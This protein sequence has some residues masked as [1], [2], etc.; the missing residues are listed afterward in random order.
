MVFCMYFIG[1]IIF[2]FFVCGKRG[3]FWC[4][5]VYSNIKL[6]LWFFICEFFERL[7]V[8]GIIVNVVDF[9]IVFINII[10]MDMWFDLLIDI[11]FCFCIC[12][13]K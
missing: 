5:F 2:E 13:L 4:I 12:I 7:K 8:E 6:V 11:L 3:S 10:C 1:K 9:G